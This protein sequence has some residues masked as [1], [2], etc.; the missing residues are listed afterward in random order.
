MQLRSH[1]K[2]ERLYDKFKNFVDDLIDVGTK[3]NGAKK[4]YEDAMNKLS[5]VVQGIS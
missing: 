2:V 4:S 1:G 5:S 3:M